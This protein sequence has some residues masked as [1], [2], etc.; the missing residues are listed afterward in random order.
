MVVFW[1]LACLGSRAGVETSRFFRPEVEPQVGGGPSFRTTSIVKRRFEPKIQI[2]SGLDL[3]IKK[4]HRR[5]PKDRR[6]QIDCS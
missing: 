6:N 2:H 1:P 3:F 4:T 5:E